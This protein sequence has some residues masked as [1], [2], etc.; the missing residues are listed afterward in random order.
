MVPQRSG[1]RQKQKKGSAG[2]GGGDGGGVAVA[3][4]VEAAKKVVASVK[5][6]E[7][8]GWCSLHWQL[9]QQRGQ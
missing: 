2:G 3:L 6:G 7:M 5:K 8:M 4:A 9:G 1:I